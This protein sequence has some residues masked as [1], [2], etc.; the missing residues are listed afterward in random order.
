MY[1]LETLD[2]SKDAVLLAVPVAVE[3]SIEFVPS[4]TKNGP[5]E[6]G[7]NKPYPPRDAVRL[8][9]IFGLSEYVRRF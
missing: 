6:F 2:A 8:P 3:T 7:P 5:L 1:K 4:V 9:I